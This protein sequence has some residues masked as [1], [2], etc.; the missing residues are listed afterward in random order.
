[1]SDVKTDG[2]LFVSEHTEITSSI[3]KQNP[4]FWLL[5]H[6][7]TSIYLIPSKGKGEKSKGSLHFYSPKS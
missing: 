4:V 1:M 6:S 3:R 2:L 7:L 5:I